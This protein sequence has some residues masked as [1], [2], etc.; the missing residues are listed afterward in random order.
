MT[1]HDDGGVEVVLWEDKL[2]E[3]V[4]EKEVVKVLCLVD[5]WDSW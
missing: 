3:V 1:G 2:K 4:L 5:L